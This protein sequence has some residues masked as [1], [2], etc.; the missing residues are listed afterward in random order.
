MVS[1]GGARGG[2]SGRVPRARGLRS[3][4][5]RLSNCLSLSSQPAIPSPVAHA[6]TCFPS[7][8]QM[9]LIA[10]I[11]AHHPHRASQVRWGI[12][13][14]HPPVSPATDAAIDDPQHPASLPPSLSPTRTCLCSW[15]LPP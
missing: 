13:D 10:A 9:S 15:P 8:S 6:H 3:L 12:L 11:A 7:P 4:I 5:S 1:P 14:L 2:R